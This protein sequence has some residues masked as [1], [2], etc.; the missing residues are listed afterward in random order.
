MANQQASTV[1][2]SGDIQLHGRE[3]LLATLIFVDDD[4]AP[5]DM[6]EAVV[7]FETATFSKLLTLGAETNHLV[8][9]LNRGELPNS[10]GHVEDFIVLDESGE[11]PHVVWSGRLTMTGW[12]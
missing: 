9:S 1:T 4:G 11:I 2:A 6:S 10:I 3:G 8:L 12:I 5:T 7:K